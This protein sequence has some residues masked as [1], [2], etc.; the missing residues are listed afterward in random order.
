[1]YGK[2]K[3]IFFLTTNNMRLGLVLKIAP[4]LIIFYRR[5]MCVPNS[6]IVNQTSIYFVSFTCLIYF[7]SFSI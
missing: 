5:T 7:L 6:S 3:S 2:L 1:M 4:I